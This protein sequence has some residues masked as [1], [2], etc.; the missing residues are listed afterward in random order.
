MEEFWYK[1]VE[2]WPISLR[3]MELISHE[4]LSFRS[5]LAKMEPVTEFLNADSFPDKDSDDPR[6]YERGTNDPE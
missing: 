2:L 3:S 1:R 6:S 4:K 5:V